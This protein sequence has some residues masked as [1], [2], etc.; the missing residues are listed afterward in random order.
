MPV[1]GDMRMFSFDTSTRGPMEIKGY[2]YLEESASDSTGRLDLDSHTN[3]F[4]V[5]NNFKIKK[6]IGF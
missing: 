2:R 6:R 1:T 3:N 5:G 4:V